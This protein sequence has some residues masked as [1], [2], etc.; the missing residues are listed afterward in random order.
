MHGPNVIRHSHGADAP[1]PR[2]HRHQAPE[3]YRQLRPLGV[4]GAPNDPTLVRV[5]RSRPQHEPPADRS[6]SQAGS[7]LPK[8]QGVLATLAQHTDILP[9]GPAVP[10]VRCPP[11][12]VNPT[13]RLEEL[14]SRHGERR[15]VPDRLCITKSQGRWRE[16]P[17][18]ER[19]T[20]ASVD[21]VRRSTKPVGVTIHVNSA[22]A[23]SYVPSNYG[24]GS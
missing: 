14:I 5:H 17:S 3:Q 9:A 11:S 19:S 21:S 7:L 8:L 24:D 10:P 23:K 12:G 13:A 1:A 2:V 4:E 6:R 20:R 18:S 22:V 15:E 16:E